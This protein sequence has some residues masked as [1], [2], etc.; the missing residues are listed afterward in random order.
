LANGSS[1]SIR[2]KEADLGE[3]VVHPVLVEVVPARDHGPEVLLPVEG[4]LRLGQVLEGVAL[5]VEQLLRAMTSLVSLGYRH[6][7]SAIS[8]Y[9]RSP[10]PWSDS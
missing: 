5:D 1:T 7:L 2:T 4:L 10:A 3:V 9:R 8:V 6:R